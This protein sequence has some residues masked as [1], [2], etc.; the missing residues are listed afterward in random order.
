LRIAQQLLQAVDISHDGL[1]Q[2]KASVAEPSQL[3]TIVCD[4][5]ADYEQAAAFEAHVK[6]WG[7][8]DTTILCAGITESGTRLHVGN[9]VELVTCCARLP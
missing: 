6:Q 2:L 7:S 5:S 3:L 9:V 4:V 1:E 8:L